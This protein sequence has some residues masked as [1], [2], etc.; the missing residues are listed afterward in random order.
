ML[1]PR[2]S[3][4]VAAVACSALLAAAC[5]GGPAAGGAGPVLPVTDAK[6]LTLLDATLAGTHRAEA[7]RARDVYRH[8]RETLMFFGLRRDLTVMEIWPGSGGWYTEIL[9]PLL[10]EQGRYIA[11]NWDPVSESQYVQDGL[12]AFAAKLAARP[13]LYDRATVTALQHP[14][15]M[16]PVP[17]GSVDMVLTFRN[18]H[19]WMARDAAGPMLA[20]MYTALKPGGILGIVEHRAADNAPQDPQARSGYVREDYAIAL[21][22]AAGFELVAR[23]EINANP[24]DTKDYPRGVWTLPP[25]YTLGDVDRERYAAIGESDRFTL[26]FRKPTGR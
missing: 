24:R 2:R 21:A 1:A 6:T 7:N 19:N 11:A 4:P 15:A 8:P 25:T 26:R 5:A 16:Q 22:E 14:G 10:R 20:A 23:S 12:R 17:P 9:A 13:D 18:L 3:A